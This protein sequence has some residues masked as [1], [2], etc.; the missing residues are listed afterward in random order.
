MSKLSFTPVIPGKNV[1]ASYGKT[2]GEAQGWITINGAH[3]PVGKDGNITGG[4]G[5]KG[6]TI[7]QMQQAH[8]APDLSAYEKALNS[9][10]D[11]ILNELSKKYPKDAR[12]HIH[13]TIKPTKPGQ[14]GYFWNRK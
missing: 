2:I 8:Q 12:Y 1:P 9:G 10:N 4:M 11:K 14:P 7:G 6:M 3:V 5:G 13:E